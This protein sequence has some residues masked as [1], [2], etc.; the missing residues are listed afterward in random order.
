MSLGWGHGHQICPPY[1]PLLSSQRDMG[2]HTSE[3]YMFAGTRC[4]AG[5]SRSKMTR[6]SLVH[7]VPSS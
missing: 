7:S 2:S 1:D 3:S 5:P 6:A 4:T